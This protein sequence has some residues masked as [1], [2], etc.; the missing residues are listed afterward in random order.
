MIKGYFIF[1]LCI[2]LWI[3]AI[4]LW[5]YGCAFD[6]K[7]DIV[8]EKTCFE[9]FETYFIYTEEYARTNNNMCVCAVL[10]PIERPQ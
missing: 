7:E 4:T 2:V 10:T 5:S 8:C 3:A 6:L 9:K 1:L